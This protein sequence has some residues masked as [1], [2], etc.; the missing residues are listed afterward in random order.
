ME[1]LVLWVVLAI[2]ICII[3]C[4]HFG[5]EGGVGGGVVWPRFSAVR[6]NIECRLCSIIERRQGLKKSS[7]LVYG[8][9]RYVYNI[10]CSGGTKK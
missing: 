1:E 5:V 2:V 7:R 10:C 4:F 9:A 8:L 3:L 6:E